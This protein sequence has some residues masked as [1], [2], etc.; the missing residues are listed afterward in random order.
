MPQAGVVINWACSNHGTYTH[1]HTHHED[2]A[3]KVHTA[4]SWCLVVI[5]ITIMM[6]GD[7]H[8]WQAPHTP[9]THLH[10]DC[11]VTHTGAC[12]HSVWPSHQRALGP[13]Q[14]HLDGTDQPGACSASAPFVTV[15]APTAQGYQLVAARH[16]WGSLLS[17]CSATAL[18]NPTH[19]T[20]SPGVSLKQWQTLVHG[21]IT[22]V[23]VHTHTCTPTY[24]HSHAY[25]AA[26]CFKRLTLLWHR[27]N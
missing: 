25:V 11:N 17:C 13:A 3:A 16:A 19:Q 4:P 18:L 9:A 5:T 22:Q 23:R 6:P 27:Q 15:A 14:F 26:L 10:R 8:S 20:L 24:M 7:D 21:L 12:P 2:D 1:T